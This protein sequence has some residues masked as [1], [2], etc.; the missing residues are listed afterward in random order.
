MSSDS[1]STHNETIVSFTY[2]S[3]WMLKNIARSA[4][5][6][7]ICKDTTIWDKIFFPAW[8][9]QIQQKLH[10]NV[11]KTTRWMFWSGQVKA[12]ISI[13][14]RICCWTWKG[15]LLFIPKQPDRAWAVLQGRMEKN[16]IV[17]VFRLIDSYPHRLSAVIAAKGALTK[18]WPE[19]AQY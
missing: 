19:G 10:R 7:L 14:L 6:I 11:L 4:R 17:Q 9:P 1:S 13:Q 3:T 18:Y 12:Q 15:R 8:Q 5:I 16:C 2:V